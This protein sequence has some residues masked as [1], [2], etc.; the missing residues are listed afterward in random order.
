MKHQDMEAGW[1]ELER[2]L[3]EYK[4]VIEGRNI[5]KI[6]NSSNVVEVEL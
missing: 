6:Y 4:S 3:G 1:I 2:L 5:P